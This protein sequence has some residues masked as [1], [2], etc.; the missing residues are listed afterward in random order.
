VF[1]WTLADRGSAG[2]PA[3]DTITDFNV[4]S[5]SAGGDVLDLRDLLSGEALG[6]GNTVGNLA[7]FL[8]F[9]VSGSGASA[10]TTIRISTTGQ[11][12]GGTYASAAEDQSIVLQGVDL[13]T[14]LGLASGASDAQIIQ[15]LINRGKLVVDNP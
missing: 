5:A 1:A 14:G 13:P 9:S 7:N 15:E 2:T 10:V 3:I 11:F 8:D 12:T 6:A 4:A